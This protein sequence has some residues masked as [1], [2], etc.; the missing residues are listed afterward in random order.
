MG[1]YLVF[2]LTA[3]MAA[4]GE[5]A[6]H[7]RRGTLAWPGRSAVLG[8]CAAALGLRRDDREG[9]AAL[10]AVRTA[11]AVFD[12]GL[13]L[14]D[15]HTVQTVPGAAAKRPDSRP[16]ALT[17]AGRAVHTTV[18]LRDYRTGVH[19]GVALWGAPLGALA[20]AL[21]RPVFPLYFGRKSCPLALPP[22]PRV[23][24]APDPVA[25][26]A[27]LPLPPWRGAAR[28]RLVAC[29][30]DPA[31][32]PGGRIETRRDRALDRT[33]WHFGPREVIVLSPDLRLGS[34]P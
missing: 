13:P 30:A 28:A 15:F 33:G 23:L 10:E 12:E 2:T 19:V 21:R 24:E 16:A 18:T 6:G 3:A 25:A 20:E 32:P 1:E 17:R 31:L 5:F 27:A 29:D 9:L 26:L 4:M 8:L 11:V 7:E 14:R 22:A 34:T